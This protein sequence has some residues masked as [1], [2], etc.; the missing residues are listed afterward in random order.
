MKGYSVKVQIPSAP[1]AD[2]VHENR[3]R[4]IVLHVKEPEGIGKGLLITLIRK[5]TRE[6]SESDYDRMKPWFVYYHSGWAIIRSWHRGVNDLVEIIK[7]LDGKQMKEGTLKIN[8]AGVSGTL[9]SAFHKFVPE[10]VREQK[11]YREEL[12]DR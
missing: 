2:M 8:I 1:R 6:L 10:V 9:R 5:R 3:R 4:Y 12:P 7:D 11:H